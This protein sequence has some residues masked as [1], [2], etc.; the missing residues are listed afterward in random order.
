M[1]VPEAYHGGLVMVITWIESNA[2]FD[3]VGEVN[4]SGTVVLALFSM[5]NVRGLLTS[6]SEVSACR[7]SPKQEN[8][9]TLD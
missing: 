7:W 4:V 9:A 1:L 6:V 3:L 5:E 8:H 2:A